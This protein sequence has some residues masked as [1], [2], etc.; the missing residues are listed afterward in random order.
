MH[1]ARVAE[2]FLSRLTTR[3][4]AGAIVGDLM[5]VSPGPLSFWFAVARIAAAFLMRPAFAIVVTIVSGHLIRPGLAQW[6]AMT[7]VTGMGA[8]C[9]VCAVL[10][11]MIAVYS[12]V[13]RGPLDP[14]TK[15]AGALGLVASAALTL[16]QSTWARRSAASLP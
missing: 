6:N 8:F 10:M 11:S 15:T 16:R 7:K 13:R 4:E 2:F 14:V 3:D 9:V 5:E 1:N 12:A